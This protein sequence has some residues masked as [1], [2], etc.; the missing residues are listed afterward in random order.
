MLPVDHVKEIKLLGVSLA[1]FVKAI[2]G[3]IVSLSIAY[4]VY[5]W[6]AERPTITWEITHSATH[7]NKDGK[8]FGIYSIAVMNQGHK[9]VE[10]LECRINFFGN[11]IDSF[12][13]LPPTFHY[14]KIITDDEIVLEIPLLIQKEMFSI[15]LMGSNIQT[16][17]QVSWMTM[18]TLTIRGKG[19][20]VENKEFLKSELSPTYNWL[21][22]LTFHLAPLIAI[23]LLLILTLQNQ[24]K[25]IIL[26]EQ[27]TKNLESITKLI[28]SLNSKPGRKST[29]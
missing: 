4:I 6:N 5:S 9:D 18:P 24:K 2:I 20:S 22:W 11:A 16:S 19:V 8:T 14:K 25:T 13:I 15:E 23:G 10:N 3:G 27:A 12:E 21:E 7:K 28:K 29:T 26:E 17:K 1:D